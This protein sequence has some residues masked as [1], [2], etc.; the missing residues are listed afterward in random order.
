MS[1]FFSFKRNPK[2]YFIPVVSSL[3]LEGY[4]Q[5]A[6]LFPFRIAKEEEMLI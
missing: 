1:Q 6:I 3:S 5:D 4:S 2:Q